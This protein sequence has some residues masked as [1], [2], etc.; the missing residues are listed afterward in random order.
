MNEQIRVKAQEAHNNA[1]SKMAVAM[2]EQ[3]DRLIKDRPAS[4]I[5]ALHTMALALLGSPFCRVTHRKWNQDVLDW[6][7]SL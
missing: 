1:M 3:Y 2:N 4:Y 7:L 5:Q 6:L